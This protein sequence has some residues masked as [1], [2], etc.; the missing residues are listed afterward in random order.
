VK[1]YLHLLDLGFYFLN[2]IVSPVKA[3]MHAENSL[4]VFYKA[5]P[6]RRI[7]SHGCSINL[8]ASV[9]HTLLL[10]ISRLLLIIPHRIKIRLGHLAMGQHRKGSCLPNT[11]S[12]Q[13]SQ[14]L[15]YSFRTLSGHFLC[16]YHCSY[17]FVK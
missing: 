3:E 11:E 17:S 8:L 14:A 16:C 10:L 2:V 7:L 15:Y 9:T 1:H 12:K 5:F 4:K 13:D 6:N